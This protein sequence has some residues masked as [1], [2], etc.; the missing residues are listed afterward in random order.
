MTDQIKKA[1]GL[2]ITYY[3]TPLNVIATHRVTSFAKYLNT[4]DFELD[5]LCPK[6]EGELEESSSVN[7]LYT[8]T[9]KFDKNFGKIKVAG[10]RKLRSFLF[11]K[12]LKLHFFN[13][14]KPGHFYY[15]GVQKLNALDIKQY[16]FVITSYAPLDT[17]HLGHFLKKKYPHLKWIIDYRD[18][19]SLMEYHDMGITR[20]F[21][22]KIEKEL[23][24]QADAFI[25][26]SE[27]LLQQ[28][29]EIINKPCKVIY[30]GFEDYSIES[31]EKFESQLSAIQLPIISYAGA[32]YEGERDVKP[33]L[34]F[35]KSKKIDT[36]F[37]FIF[38]L[39][40]DFD[41]TYLQ[42]LVS[43]FDIKNVIIIMD[44]KPHGLLT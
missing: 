40:N 10:L 12:C 27:V 16:D 37:T 8:S 15:E 24:N 18:L 11:H 4:S 32:L 2:L 35:I 33:F 44:L 21:F 5:V 13:G 14:R 39:I 20:S 17:I 19:Y 7:I 1:K 31:D 9:K 43:T 30:N 36:Q 29:K 6:W 41:K 22:K 34:K 38:A 26:V 42:E 28:Q 3:F 25:T 23:T